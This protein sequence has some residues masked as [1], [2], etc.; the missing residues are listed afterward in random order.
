MDIKQII[1]TPPQSLKILDLPYRD[2]ARKY[3]TKNINKK[4]ERYNPC[5]PKECKNFWQAV[6]GSWL[7]KE[8][9]IREGKRLH[10]RLLKARG[11][12]DGKASFS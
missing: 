11:R 9:G 8:A 10:K 3:C 6:L 12:K 7:Y 1:E 2:I 4:H 5:K